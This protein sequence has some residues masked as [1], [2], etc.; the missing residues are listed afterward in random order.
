[1][2]NEPQEAPVRPASPEIQQPSDP[3]SPGIPTEAPDKEPVEL[4]QH[5]EI[6][7]EK[8]GS[9]LNRTEV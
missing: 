2:P 7:P 1:M 9:L 5:P 3:A 6:S 8:P 4:P